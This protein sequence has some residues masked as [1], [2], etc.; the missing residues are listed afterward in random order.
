MTDIFSFKLL[1][2]ITVC[3]I[4]FPENLSLVNSQK[5]QHTTSS[6]MIME[7]RLKCMMNTIVLFPF[8]DTSLLE[9]SYAKAH[10]LLQASALEQP[11]FIVGYA[12]DLC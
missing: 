1:C 2:R 11:T 4:P 8:N 6:N 5:D 12:S 10:M 3:I 9:S 7:V